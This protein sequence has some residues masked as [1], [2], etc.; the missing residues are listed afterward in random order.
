MCFAKTFRNP[1]SEALM[2][3]CPL[4][5]TETEEGGTGGGP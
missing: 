2:S 4:M 3:P 5:L 1:V